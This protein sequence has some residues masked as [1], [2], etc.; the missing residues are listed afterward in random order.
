MVSPTGTGEKAPAAMGDDGQGYKDE[1]VEFDGA[2]REDEAGGEVPL[3]AGEEEGEGAEQEQ[4]RHILPVGH[5]RNGRDRHGGVDPD[6]R[7]SFSKVGEEEEQR[8][9]AIGLIEVVAG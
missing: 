8:G 2:E 6:I 7:P 5:M 3:A 4:G 9:Q 1:Q